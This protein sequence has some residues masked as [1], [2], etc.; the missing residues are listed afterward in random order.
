MNNPQER[1]ESLFDA[2]LQLSD[3]AERAAY[4]KKACGEDE[5]LRKRVESL[6]LAHEQASGFLN[7]PP[8]IT[9]QKTV[10]TASPAPLTLPST[11]RYFGDYELQDEIARGGMGIV[12]RAR[13]VSLNRTVA[14]KMIL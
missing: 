2:A 1:E 11:L 3:A 7:H 10:I 4:L 9:A 12:Y 8:D 6:I 14:V 13:Q 5:P